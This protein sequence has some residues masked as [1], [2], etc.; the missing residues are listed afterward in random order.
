M[1]ESGVHTYAPGPWHAGLAPF[2][3]A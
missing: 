3:A 1:E 2:P